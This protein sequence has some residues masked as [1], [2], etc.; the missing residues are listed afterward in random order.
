MVSGVLGDE[1]E[2]DD[3]SGYVGGGRRGKGRK[4]VATICR[5]IGN[6]VTLGY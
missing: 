3:E 6:C 1:E 5:Y 2:N 4:K